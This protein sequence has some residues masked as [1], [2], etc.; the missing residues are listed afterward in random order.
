[1]VLSE[2]SAN[3]DPSAILSGPV[4]DNGG[5]SI[6]WQMVA[7]DENFMD[8]KVSAPHSMTISKLA[9][10]LG[11]VESEIADGTTVILVHMKVTEIQPKV[12]IFA[13]L[14][15]A[16][17]DPASAMDGLGGGLTSDNGTTVKEAWLTGT[18]KGVQGDAQ[19]IADAHSITQ[20][21][22][23]NVGAVNKIKL[24]DV[25]Y[26]LSDDDAVMIIGDYDFLFS[27]GLG[28]LTHFA[29]GAMFTSASGG[30]AGDTTVTIHLAAVAAADLFHQTVP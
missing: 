5:G 17:A 23:L 25:A 30:A 20:L 4:V 13:G 8:A 29:I 27:S 16:S 9:T 28:P 7:A 19:A 10:K 21:Q 3:S 24:T 18:S 6:T 1:V 12:Q 14:W 11:A 2:F 15:D 22:H 26:G